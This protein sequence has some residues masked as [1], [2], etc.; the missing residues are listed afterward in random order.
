[1]LGFLSQIT[2]TKARK[3]VTEI[4][5]V[6]TGTENGGCDNYRVDEWFAEA[7]D[8]A[9]HVKRCFDS[10]QKALEE[11]DLDH[12]SLHYLKTFFNLDPT[13]KTIFNE[14]FDKM[15]EDLGDVLDAFVDD[16]D[17]DKDDKPR[18]FCDS[19]F[20]V[21]KD[22]D[23]AALQEGTG[24][25]Y[26]LELVDGDLVEKT[27]M[28]A[29]AEWYNDVFTERKKD[30]DEEQDEAAR[31]ALRP[32]WYPFWVDHLKMYRFEVKGDFCFAR[33]NMG[34]TE[35]QRQPTI[36][37]LCPKN[38]KSEKN[39]VWYERLDDIPEVKRQGRSIGTIALP[40][41]TFFHEMF[42]V[43]LTAAHTPDVTYTLSQITRTKALEGDTF[44][45]SEQSRSNPE[46]WTLFALAW[47]L[48][49]RNPKFTFATTK[50]V[51]R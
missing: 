13:E 4:F 49:E 43:A 33:D 32:L 45:S 5:K 29:E 38:F 46:S 20:A 7:L 41:L 51:R 36:V 50:A 17:N 44:I 18:L 3:H 23:D 21:E 12:D 24:K 40:S 27:I 1:M 10:A 22:W 11:K 25:G 26:P 30:R 39:K 42:H 34:A 28:E 2:Q 31:E 14:H 47:E 48:G 15:K 35:D 16:E 6:K 37:T 9:N 19:T 8:L